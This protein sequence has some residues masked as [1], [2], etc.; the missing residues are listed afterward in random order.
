MT[1][2]ISKFKPRE[3]PA[4][5]ARTD[6]IEFSKSAIECFIDR[7]ATAFGTGYACETATE[8][9]NDWAPRNGFSRMTATKFGLKIKEYCDVVRPRSEGRK[10]CYKLKAE[11]LERFAADDTGD[12]ETADTA[13]AI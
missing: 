13:D 2:D 9:F 6:A 10:R 3:I 8:N 7:F 1:R 12:A 11:V 5:A 4:G